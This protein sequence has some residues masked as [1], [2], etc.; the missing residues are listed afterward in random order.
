MLQDVIDD[1][2]P[3]I[4]AEL[5]YRLEIRLNDLLKQRKS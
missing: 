3:Q 4:E 2:V 5:K 1:F